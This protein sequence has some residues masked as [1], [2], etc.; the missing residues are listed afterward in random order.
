MLLDLGIAYFADLTP[1]TDA[2]GASPRTP[3]YAAPEQFEI[4]RAVNIDHR[5]DQFQVGMVL[6]E[7]LT[8]R[9]PF[10]ADRVEGYFERLVGG[11]VDTDALDAASVSEEVRAFVTR[12]LQPEPNRR[13]RT[14]QLARLAASEAFR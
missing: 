7:L 9:H 11:Q 2:F 14:P 8:S 6:F 3:K 13:Y 5:T 12:L 4:R 10:D 1:V